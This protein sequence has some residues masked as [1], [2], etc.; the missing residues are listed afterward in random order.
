MSVR[1]NAGRGLLLESVLQ[2]LDNRVFRVLV[3][4]S[5]IPILATFLIGLNETSFSFLFG[6]WNVDYPEFL[7]GMTGDPRAALIEIFRTTF[8]DSIVGSLGVTICVAAT[9]FFVPLMLE[10][11]SADLVFTKP[12]SRV[13][14]YLSRYLTGLLFIGC[15]GLFLNGG[16]FLGIGLRSGLWYPGILW[17]TLTLVYLYA[18]VHA[19]TMLIGLVTRSTPA[20]MILG[21]MFF[22]FCGCVHGGW[23][24]VEMF[25][26]AIAKTTAASKAK[27]QKAQQADPADSDAQLEAIEAASESWSKIASV[28]KSI[29]YA[30]H[31]T[32]PKTSEA[33]ELILRVQAAFGFD[34]SLA[35]RSE[36]VENEGDRQSRRDAERA[37]GK[38]ED[39]QSDPFMNPEHAF[40]ESF[41]FDAENWRYNAWF[42]LLSSLAFT[43][44]VLGFGCWRIRRI[45]L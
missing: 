36:F 5:L 40:G 34:E 30:A 16:I 29:L 4:L 3:G 13:T 23:Q 14:L 41:G 24:S 12:T 20:A 25:G 35:L 45:D 19:V 28:G 8:V 6:L 17:S 22:S 26:P 42:S 11:G 33:P 44:A 9:A 2:V 31:Y 32:L 18:L 10:K 21:I 39:P 37:R 38:G 27:A 1:M 15:L 43:L 7:S